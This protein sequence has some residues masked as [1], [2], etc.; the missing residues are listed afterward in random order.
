MFDQKVRLG[1]PDS[2]DSHNLP[3]KIRILLLFPS[4]IW[5]R[6]NLCLSEYVSGWSSV[7]PCDGVTWCTS[8]SS[9]W[10]CEGSRPCACACVRPHQAGPHATTSKIIRTSS[11]NWDAPGKN[12]T[13][14]NHYFKRESGQS[15]LL[16][17]LSISSPIHWTLRRR[18]A[19]LSRAV[20][21]GL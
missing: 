14:K 1:S 6:G 5:L 3:I 19:E 21:A 15:Q 4:E 9:V 13:R 11:E 16:S 7:R 2:P 20:C 17:Q 10:Q 12:G 8:L 18:D